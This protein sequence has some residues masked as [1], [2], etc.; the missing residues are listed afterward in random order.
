MYITTNDYSEHNITYEWVFS[1]QILLFR[2]N[3]LWNSTLF[4]LCL[5]DGTFH[6]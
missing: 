3:K 1:S 6:H 5:F 2:Q 4:L